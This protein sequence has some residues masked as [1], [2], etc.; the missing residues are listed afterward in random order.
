[1]K[2]VHFVDTCILPSL[3][4]AS[5]PYTIF[6]VMSVLNAIFARNHWILWY[7]LVLHCVHKKQSQ[8]SFSIV[9]FRTDEVS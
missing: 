1:M 8:R 5:T 6:C 7:L 2:T 9:L 4:I 3:L